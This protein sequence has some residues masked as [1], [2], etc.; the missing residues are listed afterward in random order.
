MAYEIEI[1]SALCS[2]S[3]FKINGIDADSA[4]FGSQYDAGREYAEDYCCGNM[5]FEPKSPDKEVLEKYKIDELEYWSIAS[6]LESDLS[7]GS[8]GWC[9]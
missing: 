2:T 5:T 9:S 4:D 7:F 6:K 3:K 1:Y 8:C